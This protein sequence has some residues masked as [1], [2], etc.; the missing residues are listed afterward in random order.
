MFHS[1]LLWSFGTFSEH[2]TK[3]K[4]QHFFPAHLT[5]SECLMPLC[6]SLLVL[7]HISR[8]GF[9]PHYRQGEQ[10]NPS[11]T[12]QLCLETTDG[13][14][15]PCAVQRSSQM[16]NKWGWYGRHTWHP[17]SMWGQRS[18]DHHSTWD[19]WA[20]HIF[21]VNN[22][23]IFHFRVVFNC[24]EAFFCSLHFLKFAKSSYGQI[25]TQFLQFFH[26]GQAYFCCLWGAAHGGLL[27]SECHST[28][29]LFLCMHFTYAFIFHNVK[30][31]FIIQK[32][33][34]RHFLCLL[35]TL[36]T[37]NYGS[38]SRPRDLSQIAVL[39]GFCI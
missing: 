23:F 18:P 35:N 30:V 7:I 28:S 32:F 33:R 1:C 15:L 19:N 37:V 13:E 11:G 29:G 5:K 38:F 24:N 27:T 36:I 4:T 12:A 17:Q 21:A 26:T 16:W 25:P 10:K 9:I 14:E 39:V 22:P 3:S 2:T 20:F 8:S 31:L 6:Q 34:Q